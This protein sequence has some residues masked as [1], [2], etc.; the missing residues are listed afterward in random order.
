M[1]HPQRFEQL[2][3]VDNLGFEIDVF[4]EDRFLKKF[5]FLC[6]ES[7]ILTFVQ[8][9]VYIYIRRRYSLNCR[10]LILRWTY[11]LK[12]EVRAEC[13]TLSTEYLEYSSYFSSFLHTLILTFVQIVTR[14]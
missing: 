13:S 4:F 11:S 12:R 2:L 3:D 9:T 7:V 1:A 5:L 6:S 8:M 10:I 14:I